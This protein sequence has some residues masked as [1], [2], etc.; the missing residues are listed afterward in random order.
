MQ[1]RSHTMFESGHSVK[2][3]KVAATTNQQLRE[4]RKEG[5]KENEN[6]SER[7]GKHRETGTSACLFVS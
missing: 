7:G 3:G 4:E 6:K 2:Y 1:T 5:M